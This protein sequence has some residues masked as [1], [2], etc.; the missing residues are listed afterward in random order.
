MT[1]GTQ[2][3]DAF[4][5][6]Y[7]QSII[8]DVSI[9]LASKQSRMKGQL[10]S[11]WLSHRTES[12]RFCSSGR[13]GCFCGRCGCRRGCGGLNGWR[14]AGGRLL[15]GPSGGCLLGTLRGLLHSLFC[16]KLSGF[17]NA[18]LLTIPARLKQYLTKLCRD[19]RFIFYWDYH[20]FTSPVPW[21][22]C[23]MRSLSEASFAFSL[24]VLSAFHILF[25]ILR[26]HCPRWFDCRWSSFLKK[27][28]SSL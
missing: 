8:I 14:F 10:T 7:S 4:W 5:K 2:V 15:L 21:W 19:D 24:S 17:F 9:V 11:N 28:Q 23:L 1:F 16:S 27:R 26:F 22:I 12:G 3:A 6:K 20:F 25:L 18:V 13:S